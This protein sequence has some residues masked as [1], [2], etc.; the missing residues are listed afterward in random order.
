MK[1]IDILKAIEKVLVQKT[2]E[3]GHISHRKDG[4]YQK[5]D[6]GWVRLKNSPARSTPQAQEPTPAENTKYGEITEEDLKES[7]KKELS[8]HLSNMHN[9]TIQ[10]LL[11]ELKSGKISEDQFKSQ[12]S[13][14]N[15]NIITSLNSLDSDDEE[16]SNDGDGDEDLIETPKI[17]LYDADQ[18]DLSGY[19]NNISIDNGS[20]DNDDLEDVANQILLDNNLEVN[21]ENMN[22]ARDAMISWLDANGYLDDDEDSDE[23]YEQDDGETD[24]GD[25]GSGEDLWD[26]PKEDP[27]LD[28]AKGY[29]DNWTEEYRTGKRTKEDL[30]NF[31]LK[32]GRMEDTTEN[33]QTLEN[34]LD[35]VSGGDGGD[36]GNDDSLSADLE[37]VN[38]VYDNMEEYEDGAFD[39]ALRELGVS[40]LKSQGKSNEEIDNMSEEEIVEAGDS[41][42]SS[43]LNNKDGVQKSAIRDMRSAPTVKNMGF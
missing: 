11:N 41:Y 42:W 28:K 31:A 8:Q 10:S 43:T 32:F 40:Y 30:V 6:D 39:D 7:N 14:L 22:K 5:T 3:K 16:D 18:V 24:S 1:R 21:D 17:D 25:G 13:D 35:S 12:M 26:L 20:V 23:D 36:G 9:Q 19:A 34:Y 29:I 27:D 37:W 4:D 15:N 2:Y 33:R 38:E